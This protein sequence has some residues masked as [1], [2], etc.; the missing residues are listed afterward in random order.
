MYNGRL[1]PEPLTSGRNIRFVGP[2][3]RIH[4]LAGILHVPVLHSG[5]IYDCKE[6]AAVIRELVTELLGH[7]IEETGTGPRPITKKDIVVVAPF[8]LQVRM[9]SKG[10]PG[11]RVGTVDKFQGQQAPFVIFSMTSSEGDASPRGMRTLDPPPGSAI[12]SDI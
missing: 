9:L 5:N 4:K 1:Q 12:H 11:V 3:Q 8:N 6:E 10:L 2:K 7:T